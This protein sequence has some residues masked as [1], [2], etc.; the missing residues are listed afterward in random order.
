MAARPPRRTFVGTWSDLG[1]WQRVYET[2]DALEVDESSGSTGT[3]RRV[4]YDEVLLVTFHSFIGWAVAGL[5]AGAAALMGLIAL[6]LWAGGETRTAVT[7]LFF[8]LVAAAIAV[9]RIA[10]KVEAVT[11]YGR[12]SRARVSIWLN[13]DRARTTYLRLC[14]RVRHAQERAAG[15]APPPA[16]PVASAAS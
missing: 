7:L 10:V 9:L 5:A 1:N 2:P 3:R 4:F 14:A 13:K 11:V 8:T 15:S 12:R 16:P 6:A